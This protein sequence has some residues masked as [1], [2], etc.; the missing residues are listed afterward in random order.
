MAQIT[1]ITLDPGASPVHVTVTD[2]AGNPINPADLTWTGTPS[3]IT[4]STDATGF[5]FEAAAG[6]A[7]SPAVEMT[8]TYTPNGISGQFG[9][10]IQLTVVSLQFESP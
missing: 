6:T 7:N 4:V 8:A 2:Q 5:N 3:G 9:C 1:Q 10:V